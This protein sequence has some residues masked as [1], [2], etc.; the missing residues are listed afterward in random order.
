MKISLWYNNKD[1]RIQEA[2]MPEP[3]PGEVLLKVMACGVCGSDIVEWYRLPRAPLVQGHEVGARVEKTGPGVQGFKTGDRVMAAPKVPC[4]KCPYCRDRHFPQCP[5]VKERLPGGYAQYILVPKVIVENGLYHLPE[6]ISYEQATFIEP[7]ACVI[8]AARIGGTEAKKSVLV[9]GSGV[10]GLLYIKLAHLRGS[11]IAVTDINQKRLELARQA[12]AKVLIQAGEDVPVRLV[13]ETGGK[14]QV[15]MLCTSAMP[16]I[17]QA[18]QS[19]DKG[20]SIVFFA[21][22]G[23]EKTVTIPVNDFWTKEI[24]IATSYYCGPPDIKEAIDLIA[25][26]KIEVESLVTHRMPLEEIS[27]AFALMLEGKDALKIIIEPNGPS[28]NG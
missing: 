2:D 10:S 7:L 21:V 4:M 19:V 15:V 27:K 23:P 1:I 25:S 22:P 24:R 16:A 12:G 13:K 26:G 9:M 11:L 8:R 6:S 28:R 3:G 18:W 20:G 5:E 17:E 14:A